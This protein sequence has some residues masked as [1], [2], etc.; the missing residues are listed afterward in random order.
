MQTADT[1][2]AAEQWYKKTRAASK[3]LL[4]LDMAS[5]WGRVEDMAKPPSWN[6]PIVN[7]AGIRYLNSTSP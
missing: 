2:L 1:C 4:L 6:E 7:Q 5:M 3:C